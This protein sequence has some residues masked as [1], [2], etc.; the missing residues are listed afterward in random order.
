MDDNS[1]DRKLEGE[2]N[3]EQE[4]D[5]APVSDTNSDDNN[6]LAFDP[7]AYGH[8]SV[9]QARQQDAQG[10][11][12]A[13]LSRLEFNYG[14]WTEEEDQRWE[15]VM[16]VLH[17]YDWKRL[18]G[19]LVWKIVDYAEET[20]NMTSDQT[21][22]DIDSNDGGVKWEGKG[23][24]N[25]K[26]HTQPVHA[27]TSAQ[28]IGAPSTST[29][30]TTTTAYNR[31]TQGAFE[32]PGEDHHRRR[33]KRFPLVKVSV[34]AAA[35][36]NENIPP[37]MRLAPSPME[38][39]HPDRQH[40]QLL[41]EAQKADVEIK[42]C[43]PAILQERTIYEIL[44]DYPR[45]TR[46]FIDETYPSMSDEEL[47]DLSSSLRVEGDIDQARVLWAFLTGSLLPGVAGE[48]TMRVMYYDERF[49][50]DRTVAS[51]LGRAAH[52]LLREASARDSLNTNLVEL[53][54]FVLNPPV[55]KVSGIE[56]LER[57][58]A[59]ASRLD[60]FVDSGGYG[61]DD[62]EG[63]CDKIAILLK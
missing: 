52:V 9:S 26:Q 33:S 16:R 11:R 56:V 20:D 17:G 32:T 23:D 4:G 28:F 46:E 21:R 37:H 24:R 45:I 22:S 58:L 40:G 18:K 13:Q 25:S 14:D 10:G 61:N 44:P 55:S 34:P 29:T 12:L 2:Q 47:L 19:C 27:I 53:M 3:R 59:A 8:P 15:M 6:Q 62:S 48:A 60:S 30:A 51:A 39:G 43:D 5:D 36:T 54:S 57:G 50:L 49:N 42:P 1:K 63:E 31:C 35:Y 41:T 7:R 38:T